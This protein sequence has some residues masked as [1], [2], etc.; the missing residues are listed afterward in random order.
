MKEKIFTLVI[1]LFAIVSGIRA[2]SPIIASTDTGAGAVWYIINWNTGDTG[3][4]P[5]QVNGDGTAGIQWGGA[6]PA[7]DAQLF[8]FVGD[9]V[10]GYKVYS[11][12]ALANDVINGVT[13]SEDLPLVNFAAPA[14]VV[15]LGFT[16]TPAV[17]GS[18]LIDTWF[19][20]VGQG[21]I[22]PNGNGTANAGMVQ[23][24][25]G[26]WGWDR[27]GDSRLVIRP[28]AWGETYG[29]ILQYV[30]GGNE[31]LYSITVNNGTSNLTE[32]PA[33]ATVIVTAAPP[34][35][36]IFDQWESGDVTFAGATDGI[37]TF[38]MPASNVTVAAAC[39]DIVK[40]SANT[41]AGAV[42]YIINWQC[43]GTDGIHPL[44]VNSDG[45]VGPLW[46]G[47]DPTKEN[48]LFCFIGN[49]ADGYKIYNKAAL[50]GG[51]I[52][53]NPLTEDL[54]MENFGVPDGNNWSNNIGFT[55]APALSGSDLIDTWVLD[56]GAGQSFCCGNGTA[57]AGNTL[58]YDANGSDFSWWLS[59]GSQICLQGARYWGSGYSVVSLQYVS[60]PEPLI[61]GPTDTKT[62]SD[63]TSGGYGDVIIQSSEDASGAI[64]TGQLDLT[65]G[66]LQLQPT[67]VVKFEQSFTS[68]K[69]Y[70]VGFPFDVASVTCDGVAY[71]LK[72]YD[73]SK[74]DGSYG[75]FWLKSYNGANN[76]FEYTTPE[77]SIPAGGYILQ[78]PA[79][80]STKTITFTSGPGVN[81]SS[82]TAF[83][84]EA[85][86]YK[87]TN[88]PSFMNL[89]VTNGVDA[90][91][92]YT[93]ESKKPNNFDLA[94]TWTL[95]PFE[96]L[97]IA[98]SIDQADLRSSLGVDGVTS[99]PA[100][101]LQGDK[102]VATEYYNLMGVK[103]AQPDRGNIYVVKTIFESGK[104]SV[105][106]Q[107]IDK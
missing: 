30:S 13:L 102:V 91:S 56:V 73:A 42:W 55:T 27:S 44:A 45:T 101:N 25:N 41:G 14:D 103:V 65:N 69:W 98:N 84:T 28:S 24:Y 4:K 8:C 70:A 68:G 49:Y 22:L 71:N 107:F 38:V 60:G 39:H 105:V 66:P 7:N 62:A 37:T 82:S 106:K 74:A 12:I 51:V 99:L 83:D 10:N 23:I 97:V 92:Y 88:N 61:I 47:P 57:T 53:G 2:Q 20:N 87:M 86:G 58:I 40:A 93:Y 52:N 54:P 96:S 35:G 94:T 59:G 5:W 78:V 67:G 32:A 75:D 33:G 29:A 3:I 104:T 36:Q 89:D 9:D 6:D 95:R 50:A 1:A 77:T 11:K 63:Y 19:F 34:K 17:S 43:N 48:E 15:T 16:T 46:E 85:G 64:T 72:T 31:Q 76:T 18:D 26:D 81:I 21:Q 100:V 79:D 90:N 80:L